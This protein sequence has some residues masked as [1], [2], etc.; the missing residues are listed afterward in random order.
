MVLFQFFHE[1]V[2]QREGLLNHIAEKF[3]EITSLLYCINP[4]GN[5]TIFDLDIITFK[6]NDCIYEEMDGLRF[7]IGPKS[8]YQTNSAQAYEL[9]KV[10]RDFAEIS[11]ND[12]ETDL[13]P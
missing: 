13:T 2:K 4:K 10:T 12:L 3:P 6:G 5:E 9:Y 1:D 8:F 11:E 7:K